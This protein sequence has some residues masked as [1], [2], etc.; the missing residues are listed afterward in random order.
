MFYNYIIFFYAASFFA[1][2]FAFASGISFLNNGT[3]C[4][5]IIAFTRSNGINAT[6]PERKATFQVKFPLNFHHNIP[7]ISMRAAVKIATIV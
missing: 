4:A 7:M 3:I 1:T 2:V 6:K 5:A